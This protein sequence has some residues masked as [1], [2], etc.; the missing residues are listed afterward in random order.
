MQRE[1]QTQLVTVRD[2]LRYAVTRFN[3]ARLFFGHGS[4]S[5]YDEAAY[6][7]LHTLSLPL[8][9]LEPFL[10][11]RLLTSELNTLMHII[12]RRVELRVPAAYLTNEAWLGHYKFYVDPRVI[13]PRSF[14]GELLIDR[15]AP[16][17]PDP[18]K[19][20]DVLE[21]CTGSGCLA[22]IAADQFPDA[23]VDAVDL[24]ADALAVARQNVET[25]GLKDRVRLIES[26]LTDKLPKKR[27]D[28]IL[29]NPPYVPDASMAKLP[30]EYGHEPRM[31]LAGG[32]DGMDLVRQIMRQS[33]AFLKRDG[34]LFVEVGHERAAVE[35]AFPD[36][37]LTWLSTT[38]GDDMVFMVAQDQLP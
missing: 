14:L 30:A 10:D 26:D 34:L 38:G 3:A 1:A 15:L 24:S 5:A 23:K 21:L 2:A 32:V 11:A 28:V 12:E 6:L 31:A 29:S 22:I 8:D 35:A 9:T 25:Y 16:W 18:D 33:R 4:T 36:M 37:N 20:G 17:L 19:V 7:V 13:V 27:Y